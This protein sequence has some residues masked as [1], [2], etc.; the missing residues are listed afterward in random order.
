MKI[1][2]TLFAILT[3]MMVLGQNY[4]VTNY[5]TSNSGIVSN[6][7]NFIKA[8]SAG[9][10]WFGTNGSGLSKYDG[11]TWTTYTTSDGL[12]GNTVK[13]IDIDQSGNVWIATSAGVSRF[14]GTTFTTL[15]SGLPNTDVRC[16][17]IDNANVA[18]VGTSGGGVAK[19]NGSSWT[20]Y[21]TTDGLAQNFVQA[22][23]QD[24]SGNMWFATANGVSRFNGTSTWTTYTSSNGLIANGDE[25]ISA[26]T[27]YDGNIWFGSKP[28]FG[29]GGGVS[30]FNGS[31]WTTYNNT[32]GLASNEVRGISSDAMN[33]IWFSTYINGAS[34]FRNGTFTTY[35]TPQGLVSA[36]QQCVDVAPTGEVWIGTSSGVSRI[37]TVKY[38][39]A[40]V[41]HNYCGA[42][43]MGTI[44][45]SA[46]TI[47]APMYYSFDNGV[48]YSTSNTVSGLTSGFYNVWMTDSSMFVQ[49]PGFM[50]EDIAPAELFSYNSI[51]ICGNDSTQ[52]N[53]DASFTNFTWSPDSLV[54]SASASNPFVWGSVSQYLYVQASDS[55][56]CVVT[57][58]VYINVLPVPLFNVGV[59]NDSVFTVDATFIS[60]QWYW[61]GDSIPGANGQSYTAT[62]PGIYT[63]CVTNSDGCTSCSGMIHYQNTGWQ[64]HD[65][66][67]QVFYQD[68]MLHYR[69]PESNC[70]VRVFTADGRLLT[71]FTA[72]E[73]SGMVS[74]DAGNDHVLLLT[75]TGKII[76]SVKKLMAE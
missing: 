1:L 71:Q 23:T 21:N 9:V 68:G 53:P 75:V 74:L 30:M 28:G 13:G 7:V 20:T 52:L 11:S 19:R 33:R 34:H 70:L 66:D 62:Q 51:D 76:N 36:T 29:I 61:Y 5:T 31:T 64:D 32:N 15:N 3:T 65:M 50:I 25:V 49:G 37:I 17:Y 63:V 18:W 45:V 12:V 26:T 35:S 27:D 59:A 57:D 67:V 72:V 55:N 48:T 46:G 8:G 54:S 69:F 16:V 56:S 14:N 4:S 6:N 41:T 40:T 73:Q 43:N 60:Y 10:V 2:L 39:S 22:I 42:T 38:H 58:S 44:T 24:L 47:N